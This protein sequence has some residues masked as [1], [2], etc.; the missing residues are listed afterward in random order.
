M[1]IPPVLLRIKLKNSKIFLILLFSLLFNSR[2]YGFEGELRIWA[3]NTDRTI[4]FTAEKA[5]WVCWLPRSEGNSITNLYNTVVSSSRAGSYAKFD[6]E[7]DGYNTIGRSI[8]KIYSDQSQEFI[9]FYTVGYDY[10]DLDI[11]YNCSDGLFYWGG[12]TLQG[13][14]NT[15]T[16]LSNVETENL[17]LLADGWS[18]SNCLYLRIDDATPSYQYGQNPQ[19]FW[20]QNTSF[21]PT[22]Y[23]IYRSTV[24]EPDAPANYHLI[25]TVSSSYNSYTDYDVRIE[26]EDAYYCIE[27]KVRP[28]K[29]AGTKTF[30]SN[31][32]N[33]VLINGNLYINKKNIVEIFIFA[34]SII[35][36]NNY[37]NPF[38]LSTLIQ[39]KYDEN[40]KVSLK[41]YDILGKEIAELFN[42]YTE[43]KMWYEVEFNATGLSSGIYYY[44][45]ISDK[46]IETKKMILIK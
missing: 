7:G 15:G 41:I 46:Y 28:V 20:A 21:N 25:T 10:S 30:Y 31:F 9:Y 42:G 39:F 44:R 11:G 43:Q 23:Q 4:T 32:S 8:Y 36:S 29:V 18:Q 26:D 17:S 22:G 34:P 3:H 2:M 27:Y 35:F 14:I 5:D 16:L 37:P 12:I 45:L 24:T 1:K 6:T 33:S 13:A 38:N 19:I 40:I